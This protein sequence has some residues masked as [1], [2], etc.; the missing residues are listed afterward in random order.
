MFFGMTIQPTNVI[1]LDM[2]KQNF[3]FD[4]FLRNRG[5]SFDD[6]DYLVRPNINHQHNPF[7]LRGIHQ[8]IDLL[9][10]LKGQPMAII[11]DYDADGVLSGT[12]ARV[13]LYLFGFGDVY[14]YPP[15]TF[16]GYG[17]SKRS[18]DAV[19]KA[20]PDT[21]VII[22]T[23][24]GSNAHEGVAYA[25]SLG[26]TVL[27]TDHHLADD[28]PPADAVVN[29]NRRNTAKGEE[30]ESYPFTEISGTTVIYKTL[31]AYAMK[32]VS[33]PRVLR[34]YQS[35]ILLVGISTISDVMPVLN[36]NRYYVTEAVKMFERFVEGHTTERIFLHDDS[37]L[38]QYYRGVDLLVFTL[39]RHGKL[40][41]GIDSDTF[42]FIIGPMFNSP[43]RMV[44]DSDVAF[45]LFQTKQADLFDADSLP[46]DLLFQMNEDRKVLVRKFTQA[47]LS[48]I[49]ADEEKGL[50]NP[51]DYTVINAVTGSGIVGLLAGEF[52]KRYRLPSVVFSVNKPILVSD[53]TE[54]INV[55][56]N[57]VKTLSGSARSP[58]GFDIHSFLTVID[59]ENPG[60]IKKWGGHAGAAGITLEAEK[61][62]LFRMI[63]VSKLTKILQEQ[64]A[65]SEQNNEPKFPLSGEYVITTDVYDSLVNI[66]GRPEGVTEIRV[67]KYAPILNNA[68]LEASVRFFE[69]LEPFGHGFPKPTFSVVV[70]M[71]DCQMYTMGA[72][73]QHA[74][75][76]LP[77]GLNIIYWNGAEKLAFEGGF[78]PDGTPK[79][80]QR[81]FSITGTLGLNAFNG[82]ESLQL[83][84]EELTQ[85]GVVV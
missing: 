12:V 61:F 11:P 4:S 22:T 38:G 45:R 5:L 36:E 55:D 46:S 7:L 75:L 58:E 84:V 64:F 63:F 13:G 81:V 34:D 80:D 52:S 28:D 62:E 41:Y 65:E 67:E 73:N 33:D 57:G 1:N 47:L 42:G 20:H 51:L 66:Y 43:R 3:I 77:N 68:E 69:Q 49:E 24:N 83:I 10:S 56:L 23:D 76:L 14:V 82:T 54:L 78:N 70:S 72:N 37:P 31:A 19:L 44:G 85:V 71:L 16:D 39:N 15:K 74:K 40:K 29:P 50:A 9:H 53:P 8:W 32:Y 27:V 21:K 2:I 79:K 59:Q 26:L 60:L 48:R 6:V 25:K 30:N 17:L 35:L 18:V